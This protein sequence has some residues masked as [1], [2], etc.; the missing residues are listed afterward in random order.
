MAF[1]EDRSTPIRGSEAGR[2]PQEAGA[3]AAWFVEG[4]RSELAALE[5]DGGAQSYEL[6]SGKLIETT[7]STQAVYQFIL[8]D[9]TLIPE[10]ATGK[11]KTAGAEFNATVLGQRAD[12][13]QVQIEGSAPLP[14][15]IPRAILVVDETALLRRLAEVLEK[16]VATPSAVGPLGTLVFHPAKARTGVAQ[17]PLISAF[18]K[19]TGEHRS[20]LERACGSSLTYIWGPPGTGKT[21]AIAHLIAALVE[22]GERVLVTSHTHA[23]VDQALY[24]AVQPKR[25][26]TD[27]AGPLADHPRLNDGRFLRIGRVTDPK[28]PD[29]VRLDRV[30]EQKARHFETRMVELETQAKP[31]ADRRAI[32][33]AALSEWERLAELSKRHEVARE[34]AEQAGANSEQAEVTISRGEDL[35]KRRRA[36]LEA[37]QQAWFR[38]RAKTERATRALQSAEEGLRRA[39]EGLQAAL[40]EENA[41]LRVVKE[42]EDALDSQQMICHRL[43]AKKGLETDMAVLAGQLAPIEDEIRRLQE[44]ISQI[45]QT[46][47]A[48]AQVV[49]CT[50][51]K[52]YM[53][54]ELENQQ[55][56]AVIVDEVSMA[57]PPLVFLAAGRATTRVVLVGDFWQLPPIVRSDDP[58]S[59]V[60]LGEDVFH[61]SGVAIGSKP[62]DRCPVLTRLCTSNEWFHRS[63]M[64]RGTWPMDRM[65]STTTTRSRLGRGQIG[66]DSSQRIRSSSSTRQVSI[67]GAENSQGVS[68]GSTS[69]QQMLPLSW[70][71]WLR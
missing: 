44:V 65:G 37:A 22:R 38:R 61:L 13:L 71:P 23:A 40:R 7:G 46:V 51:T 60:R 32:C 28:V 8:A 53:G 57:L 47:I 17:L 55:F 16:V 20:V 50:L 1:S 18:I 43:P 36:E 24:E 33:R 4:L 31:I 48:S 34:T 6:L 63:L 68:A 3:L 52:C 45:E 56:H 21:F 69:T 29:T 27:R 70:P 59:N 41:A 62:A 11:L 15:G 14:S 64:S 26:G 30:V 42:V 10:D 58:I 54:R 19:V 35:L 2:P 66:S 9:G 49:F 39:T 25:S 67:V 12:R 5:K